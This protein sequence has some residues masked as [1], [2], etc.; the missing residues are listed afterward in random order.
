MFRAQWLI[1]RNILN[2]YEAQ[3]DTNNPI[4][5]KSHGQFND[6]VRT[7]CNKRKTSED[8]TEEMR[9]EWVKE[10]SASWLFDNGGGGDK[11]TD[12]NEITGMTL[13][14]PKYAKR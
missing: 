6:K 11:S 8:T 7:D 13:L 9:P 12:T 10:T 1:I 2:H 14:L 5:T 4:P 3:Q